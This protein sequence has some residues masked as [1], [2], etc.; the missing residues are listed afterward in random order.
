MSHKYKVGDHVSWN[1]EAGT[2][3]RS[4]HPRAHGWHRIHGPHTARQPGCP[5]IRDQERQDRSC[6]DA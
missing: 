4:H 1:S 2:G 5:A 3:Q 6:G